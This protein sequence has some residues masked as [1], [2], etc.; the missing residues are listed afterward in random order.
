VNWDEFDKWCA[1][2]CAWREDR[3]SDRNGDRD[4]IRAVIHIIANRAKAS[5][6]SWAQIVYARLQFSSMTYGEDPQ[7]TNVPVTPDPQFTDCYEIA[8]TIKNGGDFDLTNGA[9][10]Y[11]ASSLSPAP[12]WAS[13]M[14]VTAV[15]GGQ[16]YLK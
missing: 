10:H 16:I 8:N 11:Y 3:G 12:S 1:A 6:K 4:G 15:L 9:T 13:S 2:L 7:L 5:N 14:T